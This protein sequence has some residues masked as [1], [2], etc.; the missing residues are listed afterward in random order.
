MNRS[1][2]IVCVAAT[3]SAIALSAYAQNSPPQPPPP[4][5][6]VPT[7][8]GKPTSDEPAL[9]TNARAQ[10]N[11]EHKAARARCEAGPQNQRDDCLR[12][13]DARYDRALAGANPGE[14]G[15]PGSNTGFKGTGVK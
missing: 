13:A 15:N 10:A 11:A 7:P 4:A 14:Q 12:Q 6:K 1:L 3:T 9:T 8:A 5:R 2:R